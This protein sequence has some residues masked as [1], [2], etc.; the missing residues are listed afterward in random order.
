M[1]KSSNFNII[2][3][4]V[5][6]RFKIFKAMYFALHYSSG[7]KSLNGLNICPVFNYM[8]WFG[9]RQTCTSL[10]LIDDCYKQLLLC[11]LVYVS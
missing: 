2:I 9:E 10:N 1:T 5:I 6:E 11:I 7:V 4:S 8:S 3:F